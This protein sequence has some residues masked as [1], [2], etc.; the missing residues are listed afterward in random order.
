MPILHLAVI[1]EFGMAFIAQ[2]YSCVHLWGSVWY[3][4]A[5][6][7]PARPGVADASIVADADANVNNGIFG[8]KWS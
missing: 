8:N 6:I 1:S 5:L 7:V 4:T 2:K 3:R